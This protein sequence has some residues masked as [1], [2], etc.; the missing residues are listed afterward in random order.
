MTHCAE[1]VDGLH[2]LHWQFW[3]MLI[4]PMAAV[5]LIVWWASR[6]QEVPK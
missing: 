2:C 6:N 3:A 4:A 1:Y 5:G